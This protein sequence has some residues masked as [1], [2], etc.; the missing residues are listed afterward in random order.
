MFLEG[1]RARSV[2]SSKTVSPARN[3]L[4]RLSQN[5]TGSW[6]HPRGC[7][8]SEDRLLRLSPGSAR[9]AR[10]ATSTATPA[11]CRR[12]RTT[13][14]WTGSNGTDACSGPHGRNGA[15]VGPGF[16]FPALSL[17]CPDHR[18]SSLGSNSTLDITALRRLRVVAPPASLSTLSAPNRGSCGVRRSRSCVRGLSRPF[19]HTLANPPP[20]SSLYRLRWRSS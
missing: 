17:E 10:A 16:A 4:Q 11:G 12:A 6:R 18:R 15:D 14:A 19:L 13:S 20:P 7:R 9:A 2:A 3:F 8:A 5:R 1:V